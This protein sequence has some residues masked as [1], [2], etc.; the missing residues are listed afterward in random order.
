MNTV[1]VTAMNVKEGKITLLMCLIV[2]VFV[3]CVYCKCVLVGQPWL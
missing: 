1:S 3:L 2:C